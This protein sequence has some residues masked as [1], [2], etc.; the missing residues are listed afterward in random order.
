MRVCAGTLA[1]AS[2]YHAIVDGSMKGSNL[3]TELADRCY[4]DIQASQL[5]WGHTI[6]KHA[7][8][9]AAYLTP[10]TI[11]AG[12]AL[13]AMHNSNA[14]V[15]AAATVAGFIG[16]S[17]VAGFCIPGLA[18]TS[19]FFVY[20]VGGTILKIGEVASRSIGEHWDQH[21][22][23]V[24]KQAKQ[25]HQIILNSLID[26]YDSIGEA[27]K[28]EFKQVSTQDARHAAAQNIKK[29]RE[30]LPEIEKAFSEVGLTSREIGR[31]LENLKGD[32]SQIDKALFSSSSITNRMVGC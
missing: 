23:Q 24:E 4:K 19:N 5:G 6:G 27:I 2:N 10:L 26:T 1:G 14:A 8:T 11:A 30:K 13:Y 29:I 20:L 32:I 22:R 25:N 31:V 15:A 28:K 16:I 12:S 9:T 7:C 17:S 18:A 21:A 3:V